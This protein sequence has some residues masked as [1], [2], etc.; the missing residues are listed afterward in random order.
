MPDGSSVP[1]TPQLNVASKE[2]PAQL[3]PDEE[4]DG[5][6]GAAYKRPLIEGCPAESIMHTPIGQ[7]IYGSQPGAASIIQYAS[8]TSVVDDASNLLVDD[9]SVPGGNQ[10][11]EGGQQQVAHEG[12]HTTDPQESNQ[13]QILMLKQKVSQLEAELLQ[14]KEEANKKHQDDDQR[15]SSSS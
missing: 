5:H 1:D 7:S 6:K 11:A 4:T 13:E 14:T 2:E 15:F 3:K 9:A 12:E 10:R 8:S